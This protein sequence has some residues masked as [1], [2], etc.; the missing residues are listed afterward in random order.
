MSRS[1]FGFV[2]HPRGH[3]INQGR[4]FRKHRMHSLHYRICALLA[5]RR[6]PIFEWPLRTHRF[7]QALGQRYAFDALSLLSKPGLKQCDLLS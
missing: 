3:E 6:K 2:G 1:G 4:V 7:V 5:L